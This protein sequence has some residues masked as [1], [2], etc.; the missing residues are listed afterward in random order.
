MLCCT[1]RTA[2][3]SGGRAYLG[4]CCAR[5]SPTMSRRLTPGTPT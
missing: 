2:R 5:F 1:L 3:Q 4:V